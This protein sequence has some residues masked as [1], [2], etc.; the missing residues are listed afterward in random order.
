[1][2]TTNGDETPIPTSQDSSVTT[3]VDTPN[4][5]TTLKSHIESSSAADTSSKAIPNRWCRRCGVTETARWRG[6]PL[7]KSTLC[8]ACGLRWKTRGCPTEG[9]NHMSYPPPDLPVD[10]CHP[11]KRRAITRTRNRNKHGHISKADDTSSEDESTTPAPQVEEHIASLSDF[12]PQDT[13]QHLLCQR[14]TFLKAGLY[15]KHYKQP[16]NGNKS[17][18]KEKFSLPLPMLQGIWLMRKEKDFSL[19]PSIIEEHNLGILAPSY[20]H[21]TSNI[22]LGGK[23]KNKHGIQEAPPCQCKRPA[24]GKMGCGED[25]LNRMMFYECD[26]RTCASG[27]QCGNRRFQK[28]AF[29]KELEPFQTNQGRGWGL[30]TLVDIP[31]GQLITEYC[32]E[33]ITQDMCDQRMRT[34]YKNKQNFYFLEYSPGLVI[35]AGIKGSQA[36]FIN[37]S[38]EPNCHIEK[39]SLRNEIF[40][41]VFASRDI[42]QGEELFYDYNFATFGGGQDQTCYCGSPQCRGTM[43]R[44]S[45]RD[46]T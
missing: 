9:F 45:R 29:V 24:E 11:A 5:T 10:Q 34:T 22:P 44:K 32:G 35:D 7:G 26:P 43:G 21:I 2:D 1:M 17:T 3:S 39:W 13:F 28:K 27:D 8:N 41:G 6:G 12:I 25:C 16:L 18:T 23:G 31:K 37:H 20:I 36:R 40:V 19:P 46:R 4:D 38:C 14:K 42:S 15:S 30:R 33:I